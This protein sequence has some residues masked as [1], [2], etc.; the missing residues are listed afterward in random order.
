MNL[1][2]SI[3]SDNKAPEH[4]QL[5]IMTSEVGIIKFP[6]AREGSI[7]S[8]SSQETVFDKKGKLDGSLERGVFWRGYFDLRN[9]VA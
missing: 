6:R 3:L 7:I 1:A 2:S 8:P 5:G 4:N 9:T